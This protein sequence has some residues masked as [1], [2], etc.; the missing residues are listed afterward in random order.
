MEG[1]NNSAL[2][3][4]KKWIP[5]FAGMTARIVKRSL[6]KPLVQI[7]GITALVWLG[8]FSGW[9]WYQNGRTV[10]FFD[11]NLD[12]SFRYSTKL[13]GEE[14]LSAQDKRDK[15]V[16]RIRSGDDVK[17]NLLVTVR[18]EEGLRKVAALQKQSIIDILL[19]NFDRTIA[20]E[21]IKYER[22]SQKKYTR[23]GHDA[24]EIEFTYLSPYGKF[25]QEKYL[26]IVRDDDSAVYV[27]AQG[28]KDDFKELTN[29][30]FEKIFTTIAFKL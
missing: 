17:K 29:D 6:H 12:I 8:I 19:G 28:L 30:Y 13:A 10:G 5:T 15:I 23:S 3:G 25:I 7:I 4:R 26:I 21:H 16:Y 1:R 11:Q 27:S 18:Y 14:T 2:H 22:Q 9:W 20:A 24:A